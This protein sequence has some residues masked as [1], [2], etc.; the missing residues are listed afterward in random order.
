MNNFSYYAPTEYLF[1]RETE[2]ETGRKAVAY[3]MKRVL[4]AYGGGSVVRS[5]L[6]QR[7]IDSLDSAGV[8][9]VE[10]SGIKPNPTDDR[11]YEGIGIVRER[12]ID[13]LIA[14]GGGSVIDTAKAI[15]LGAL[16]DGDFWDFYAGKATPERALPVGVV[17]TIPA[18]GSEGSGNSVITKIDGLHKI[19]LRTP[20]VLRPKFSI[21]NPETTFTLPPFQ[22]ACGIADMMAHIMERYFSPTPNVEVTDHLCQGLLRSIIEVAPKVMTQPENY[23]ARA[24]IMWAGTMAHN[25]VCGCGRVED[26]VSHF[27][28][29]EIS[30]VYGVTHGAGL[31]VV[32]PAYLE[33]MATHAPSKPAQFA[34]SV[35]NVRETDDQLAAFR[36]A[37]ALRIFFRSLELPVTFAELGIAEPDIELLVNKLCENKGTVIGGYYRLNVD[38]MRAIYEL[39]K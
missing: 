21:L 6:L 38:D 26:W 29:H 11:V 7:V 25:G 30:A 10:F 20:S 4:V 8:E 39:M 28:E 1:G 33:F 12:N 35:F 23:D 36:G 31:A 15:A 27:M 13:G 3:G 9:H 5:G 17:L 14:V 24:N 22:T 16:Y 34:R 19:S 37:E 32:F 18:A 2:K